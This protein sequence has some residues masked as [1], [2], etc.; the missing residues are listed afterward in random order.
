MF[1]VR[2]IRF[3]HAYIDYILR[4]PKF[5]TIFFILEAPFWLSEDHT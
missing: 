5:I 2:V 4:F 3:G 1:L